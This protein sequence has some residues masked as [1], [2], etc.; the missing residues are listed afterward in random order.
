MKKI[1]VSL[2]TIV[3]TLCAVGCSDS[4]NVSATTISQFPEDIAAARSAVRNL[5]EK[6]RNDF[7]DFYAGNYMTKDKEWLVVQFTTDEISEYDY[8]LEE[9]SCIKFNKVQYSLDELW[10]MFFE[11]EEC[12]YYEQLPEIGF[13]ATVSEEYNCLEITVYPDS[14]TQENINTLEEVLHAYPIKIVKQSDNFVL[15]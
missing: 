15:L 13:Y 10:E 6:D 14:Y 3:F 8:L 5:F 11:F 1:I 12:N 9:H 7:P 2:L 4:N